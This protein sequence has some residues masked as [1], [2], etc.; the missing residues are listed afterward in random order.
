MIDKQL[1]DALKAHGESDYTVGEKTK[2]GQSV[3]YR[4][5]VGKPISLPNAAILAKYLG[6]ELRKR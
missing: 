4:F 1:R 3:V 6:W 2:L 5:K